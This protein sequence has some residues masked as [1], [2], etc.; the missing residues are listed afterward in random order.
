MRLQLGF[1]LQNL[2]KVAILQRSKVI[3]MKI[4]GASINNNIL[5]MVQPEIVVVEE[6]AE[7]LEPQLLAA[8]TKNTKH[9]IMIGDHKQLPP[10]V[11]NFRLKKNFKFGISMI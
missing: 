2:K 10:K 4:T 8:L 1:Q 5:K 3:G 7:I 11:N 6:A 9:L